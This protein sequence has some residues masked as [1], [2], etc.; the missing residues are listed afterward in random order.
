VQ[1]PELLGRKL[2]LHI[3]HPG[4]IAVWP[5][6]AGD[7]TSLNRVA[8]DAEDDGN[9]SGR[10]FGRQRRRHAAWGDDDRNP[11]TDQ[12]GRQFRKPIEHIVCPAVLD[13]HALAFDITA[14]T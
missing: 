14:L 7:E 5:G 8:A 11:T 13:R 9:C 10:G 6:E 12:I 3:A 2:P 1:K 4:H